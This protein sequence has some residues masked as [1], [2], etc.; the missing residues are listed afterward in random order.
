MAEYVGYLN[1]GRRRRRDGRKAV[2]LGPGVEHGYR[3]SELVE[4][5]ESDEV[6]AINSA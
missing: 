2:A 5:V 3:P 4:D 6:A 1:H